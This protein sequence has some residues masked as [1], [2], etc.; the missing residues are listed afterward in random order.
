MTHALDT[1]PQKKTWTSPEG[2]NKAF[3]KARWERSMLGVGILCSCS[4]PQMSGQDVPV[5]L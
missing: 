2:F 4:C 1:P 5:S 3:L